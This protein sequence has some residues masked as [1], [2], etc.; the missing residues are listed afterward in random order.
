MKTIDYKPEASKLVEMVAELKDPYKL[1]QMDNEYPVLKDP[2]ISTRAQLLVNP[3]YSEKRIRELQDE[4]YMRIC[5]KF[6]EEDYKKLKEN[7][8][9]AKE[10]KEMHSRADYASNR[11]Y[12]SNLK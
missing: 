5:E 7:E 8:R 6:A 9:R 10:T 2:H 4:L 1:I 12:R 3:P 11:T